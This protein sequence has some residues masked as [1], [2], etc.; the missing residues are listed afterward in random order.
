MT[1]RTTVSEAA[2]LRDDLR[3]YLVVMH[4]E[5][6]ARHAIGVEPLTDWLARPGGQ[7]ASA[8]HPAGPR[9]PRVVG[10]RAG[11]SGGPAHFLDDG[12]AFDPRNRANPPPAR[13]LEH[14]ETGGRG[15]MLIRSVSTAAGVPPLPRRGRTDSP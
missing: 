12:A 15:L 4:G 13:D 11:R 1:K 2:A 8:R 7:R 10:G 3:S 14:A 5:P 6:V 9:D